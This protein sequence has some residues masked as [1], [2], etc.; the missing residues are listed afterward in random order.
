MLGS[1]G[2]QTE[3]GR[4]FFQSRLALFG[5]WVC[6]VSGGFNL[7]GAILN[8]V[9]G[10]PA[11]AGTV[12]HT[13]GTAI[14]GLIW[15]AGR[16]LRLTPGSARAVDV[17]GTLLLGTS[18]SLMA[19]GFAATH[20][21]F[22][23]DPMHALFIG[24]LACTYVLFARAIALPSTPGRTAW[25]SALAIA[26]MPLAGLWVFRHP[27]VTGPLPDGG[28]TD[29]VS[30][31]VAAVVMA[32]VTSRVIFGLRAEV[33]K[34]RQLG[35][36][37]LQEKIGE[38]GMGVVYRAQHALLRR[39]T[40]IKLLAPER[41]G[42]DN[43]RR[44][45]REVQLTARLSHPSTVAIFDYGRTPDGVFYYAMELLDGTNLEQL[46]ATDGAQ[47]PGRVVHILQQ[48]AGAL[49]EAHAVGLV[50]R[51]VKPSNIILCERGG[52]P[53]V[54]KVVDFGL[55]KQ[56]NTP[57]DQALTVTAEP[58]LVGTPL[59]MAPEA[60]SGT[61]HVDARS[62]LY[63]LGAV[64]YFLLTGTPVFTSRN[65]VEICAHHLHTPPEPPSAR[66]GLAVPP[67]LERLILQ[68]LA[69]SPADRPPDARS[70]GRALAACE[71]QDP[72]SEEGAAQWWAR[73]RA[74]H[75]AETASPQEHPSVQLTAVV[76]LAN[77]VNQFR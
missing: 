3:E 15:I 5:G 53:D 31:S 11:S 38:G 60:I 34:I 26:P 57:V 71:M 65:I 20:L 10:A 6:L 16:F 66:S 21:A 18:F 76:D 28:L 40:A 19:A 64:G 22:S 41:A 67:A 37:T 75:K 39:P 7:V 4:A 59:Y 25:I 56:F 9:Y 54:A 29:V 72:W 36:Y 61:A 24:L 45:E 62:D 27:G 42:E 13:I 46:V 30:W 17:A 43:L 12:F 52:M 50:H 49:A 58:M 14:A 32:L 44:F 1:G 35:Q 8:E 23:A 74:R 48:V 63:A 73:F 2:T 68:C 33:S 55:V 69:K 70:L 77:R 47:P 51:D